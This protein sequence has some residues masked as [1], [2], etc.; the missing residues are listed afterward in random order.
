M[1]KK[2]EKKSE[3][4]ACYECPYCGYKDNRPLTRHDCWQRYS[5]SWVKV[6]NYWVI[7]RPVRK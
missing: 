2:K 5:T 4:S 6:K 1:K 3:S 7:N